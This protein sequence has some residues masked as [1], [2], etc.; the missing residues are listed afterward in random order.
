M[1]LI[2]VVFVTIDG[3]VFGLYDFKFT[4]EF[5]EAKTANSTSTSGIVD[6]YVDARFKPWFQVRAG[7]FKPYVGLERLQSG[8]DIKFIER[9]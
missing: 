9:S 6:A 8:S 7:K 4:P 3:T 5:G 1:V 2:F